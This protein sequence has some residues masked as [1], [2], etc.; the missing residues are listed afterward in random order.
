[1]CEKFRQD[2]ANKIVEA[3]DN[4]LLKKLENKCKTKIIPCAFKD[5]YPRCQEFYIECNNSFQ[6]GMCCR[7]CKLFL[8]DWCYKFKSSKKLCIKCSITPE[9]IFSRINPS[10]VTL[11]KCLFCSGDETNFYYKIGDRDPDITEFFCKTCN[12]FN[13]LRYF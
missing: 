3:L 12:S 8:C 7:K 9:T 6:L 2:F 10:P 4:N 11:L 13:S 1:M 5:E